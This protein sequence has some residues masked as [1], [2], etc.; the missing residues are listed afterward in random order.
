LNDPDAVQELNVKIRLLSPDEFRADGDLSQA[1]VELLTS[2]ASSPSCSFSLR[3]C[4][5]SAAYRDTVRAFVRARRQFQQFLSTF[6]LPSLES[7]ARRAVWLALLELV[8]ECDRPA[9]LAAHATSYYDELA[10][11]YVDV[12]EAFRPL[13]TNRRKGA[14]REWSAIVVA[15]L[16]SITETEF[17]F[18][19]LCQSVVF[20]IKVECFVL[21][22]IVGFYSAQIDDFHETVVVIVP[23]TVRHRIPTNVMAATS[24]VRR[25]ANNPTQ[26]QMMLA[27]ILAKIHDR[28]KARKGRNLFDANQ[29]SPLIERA[30]QLR[31]APRA[32][33]PRPAWI[34]RDVLVESH[35]PIVQSETAMINVR[36]LG[37]SY[38]RS[39]KANFRDVCR[40]QVDVSLL[41]Q[42][43][44][45]CR[46]AVLDSDVGCSIFYARVEKN[47]RRKNKS[48]G[49]ARHMDAQQQLPYSVDLTQLDEKVSW[50]LDE[51][52]IIS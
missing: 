30:L 35:R 24:A 38:I 28:D 27:L 31:A 19:E 3:L 13:E 26:Q 37:D 32:R 5:F 48:V 16:F 12:V 25:V 9:S 15:T 23:A 44:Q 8:P 52:M 2:A 41:A 47:M 10:L 36:G 46:R 45:E 11:L 17:R 39:R 4:D 1:L 6:L 50:A 49:I 34:P 43:M 21:Q 29:Q 22:L 20:F 51:D 42:K 7:A 18:S 14:T 40:R 33:K